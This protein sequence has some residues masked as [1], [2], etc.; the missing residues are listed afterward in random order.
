MIMRNSVQI[1][2]YPLAAF[3][4]SACGHH[5]SKP[6]PLPP[7]DAPRTSVAVLEPGGYRLQPG[8]VLRVKF[9]YHP[10]LDIKVPIRPDGDVTLQMTGPIHATGLTTTE[11]EQT[12]KERTGDRLRDPEI[13]VIVAQLGDLKIYVGGEVRIPGFVVY[14]PGMN[15]LQAIIDRGGFTDTARM[16]SV[17]RL[18]PSQ[19]E[20]QGTRLDFTKPLSEGMTEQVQLLAGDVLYVPRTFI[21]DVDVFVRLYIKEI[22]PITPKIGVGGTF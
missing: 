7:L 14:H 6:A 22:L 13:A 2:V 15:A 9:L 19:S 8:D 12:I 18:S 17:L 1:A 20:Y 3:V 4:L 10:E 21:G 11:L 5:M 16:D